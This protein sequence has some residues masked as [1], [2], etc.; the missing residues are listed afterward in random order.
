[1][2][3]KTKL[4]SPQVSP[5][6]AERKR[7]GVCCTSFMPSRTRLGVSQ[8]SPSHAKPKRFGLWYCLSKCQEKPSSAPFRSRRRALLARTTIAG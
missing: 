7:F 5:V 8:T 4:G 3:S 2:P 1:M 6:Y